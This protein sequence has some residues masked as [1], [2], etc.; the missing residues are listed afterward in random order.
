MC[1]YVVVHMCLVASSQLLT[2]SNV[3]Y[4]PFATFSDPQST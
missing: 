4:E 1:I 2:S 3:L